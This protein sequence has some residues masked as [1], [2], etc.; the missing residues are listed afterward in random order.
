MEK[1]DEEKLLVMD[2][3][4]NEDEYYNRIYFDD[5]K[6]PMCPLNNLFHVY[7]YKV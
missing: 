7:V 2:R 3:Q 6:Y 4:K 1:S 5:N